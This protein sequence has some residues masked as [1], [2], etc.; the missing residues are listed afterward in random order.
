MDCTLLS[1]ARDKIIQLCEAQIEAA[2]M[3]QPS[4][5]TRISGDNQVK[6]LFLGILNYKNQKAVYQH[7]ISSYERCQR[8]VPLFGT[9]PYQFLDVEANLLFNAAAFSNKRKHMAY[10]KPLLGL[11]NAN[12][13]GLSHYKDDQGRLYRVCYEYDKSND[14]LMPKRYIDSKEGI[15][16]FYIKA[17]TTEN[18]KHISVP[19]IG[20]LITLNSTNELNAFDNTQAHTVDITING[21]TSNTKGGSKVVFLLL[22]SLASK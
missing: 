4:A 10:S 19:N 21:Y 1:E 17:K 14:H 18:K 9:P 2:K 11:P 16:Y 22:A 12:Q 7:V 5:N 3:Q 6:Q 13:F 8:A 15:I 20:Q